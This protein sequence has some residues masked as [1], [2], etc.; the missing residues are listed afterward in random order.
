MVGIILTGWQKGDRLREGILRSRAE[1]ARGREDLL[2]GV[3]HPSQ[4]HQQEEH[5]PHPGADR[6]GKTVGL[7]YGHPSQGHQ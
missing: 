4:G 7:R 3:G 2:D 5:H 6:A 1:M